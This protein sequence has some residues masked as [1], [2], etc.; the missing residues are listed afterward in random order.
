VAEMVNQ[1]LSH[2][3]I[4]INKL[5]TY[6]AKR[7]GRWNLG[8]LTFLGLNLNG[9]RLKGFTRKGS[10]LLLTRDLATF[11]RLEEVRIKQGLNLRDAEAL[12]QFL[13]KESE[14][15]RK[16]SWEKFFRNKTFGFAVSRLYNGQLNLEGLEQDFEYKYINNS[17][18]ALVGST[19]TNV[20]LNTFNSSSYANLSLCEM[21]RYN[22]LKKA[23][24]K[25]KRYFL[26]KVSFRVRWTKS[27]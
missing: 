24:D 21:F 17:W 11:C 20:E 2:Y 13:S 8:G 27:G 22:Q 25:A 23:G 18:A 14:Y 9:T 4:E 16:D 12:N 6:A 26:P 1:Y 19:L 10:R 3:G 5:K 15:P 7:A